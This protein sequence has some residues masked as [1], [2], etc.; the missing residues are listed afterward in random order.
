[1][2][3]VCDRCESKINVKP[4]RFLGGTTNNMYL[5]GMTTDI[6]DKVVDLCYQCI[7]EVRAS[8]TAM[9]VPQPKKAQSCK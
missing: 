7:V 5:F 3:L 4:I 9:L 8:I 1:M 6:M 2:A